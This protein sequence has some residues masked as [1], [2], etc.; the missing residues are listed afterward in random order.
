MPDTVAEAYEL[1]I[2]EDWVNMPQYLGALESLQG[3]PVKGV[4]ALQLKVATERSLDRY[5]AGGCPLCQDIL[6]TLRGR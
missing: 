1:Q 3:A 4:D 6:T 5:T 2:S